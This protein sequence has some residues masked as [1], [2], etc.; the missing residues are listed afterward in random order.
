[1]AKSMGYRREGRHMRHGAPVSAN[2][3]QEVEEQCRVGM[4]LYVPC[5]WQS[6]AIQSLAGRGNAK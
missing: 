6:D 5:V 4:W 2:D 1:M 3:S